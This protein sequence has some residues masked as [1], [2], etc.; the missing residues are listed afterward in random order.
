MRSGSPASPFYRSEASRLN[1]ELAIEAIAAAD[2]GRVPTDMLS[3]EFWMK[4]RASAVT[5][6]TYWGAQ[7]WREWMSDLSEEFVGAARYS[8]EEVLRAEDDF[9][10]ATYVVRGRSAWSGEPLEFRWAGVMWFRHGK[11]LRHVGC[12]TPAQALVAVEKAAARAA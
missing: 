2:A 7:G 4:N 6:H 11:V 12:S 3:P 8:L 1:V 5:D 10:L 9:V